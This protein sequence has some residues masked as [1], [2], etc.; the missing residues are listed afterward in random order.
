M[1]EKKR[2]QER[3]D[4]AEQDALGSYQHAVDHAVKRFR[5]WHAD[6]PTGYLDTEST[7][8]SGQVIDVALV[9]REGAVQF[10]SRVRPTMPIETD[11]QAVHGLSAADL[12][13]ASSWPEVAAQLRPLLVGR[14]IVAFNADFDCARLKTSDEA[15]GLA[16]QDHPPIWRCAMDAYGP[17]H[18]DWLD[19]YHGDWG[20]A[21]LLAACRHMGTPPE[22]STHQATGGAQ[23]LAQLV[24]AV[25]EREWPARTLADL[26]KD[27]VEWPEDQG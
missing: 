18:G 10:H 2:W 15:H 8:L 23:A 9:D 11:A 14:R 27:F 24:R 1:A 4:R 22:A 7:G 26:P 12:V 5:I 3:C 13:D 16:P 6:P 25:A 20:W 19:S 17:L 21:S